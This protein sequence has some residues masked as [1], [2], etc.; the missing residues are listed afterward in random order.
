[1]LGAFGLSLY[2][3]MVHPHLADGQHCYTMLHVASPRADA[4][5][6]WRLEGLPASAFC[7]RLF[8]RFFEMR[9]QNQ[10]DV[11]RQRALGDVGP[12]LQ[13]VPFGLGEPNVHGGVSLHRGLP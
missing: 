11:I 8:V 4:G 7:A 13:F 5:W 2:L 6:C 10:A 9:L 3:R 12:A 1:M